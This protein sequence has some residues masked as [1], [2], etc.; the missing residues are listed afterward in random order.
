MSIIF[1]LTAHVEKNM[2]Y[3]ILFKY[4][5]PMDETFA[6]KLTIIV[7]HPLLSISYYLSIGIKQCVRLNENIRKSLHD[8]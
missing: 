7:I 1:F 2:P 3:K 6:T 8:K 4:F 5:H